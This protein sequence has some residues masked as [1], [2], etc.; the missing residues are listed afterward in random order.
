MN[1][2]TLRPGQALIQ[3][4]GLGLAQV[5]LNALGIDTFHV[6]GISIGYTLAAIPYF[7]WLYL[8]Q[9][10]LAER[11]DA[12]AYLGVHISKWMILYL[13]FILLP[14]NFFSINPP[15]GESPWAS[16]FQTLMPVA[17]I[18]IAIGMVFLA[19]VFVSFSRTIFFL[20]NGRMPLRNREHAMLL[21]S[22][23]LGPIGL[24][25]LQP[26]LNA[27]AGSEL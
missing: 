13:I 20:R 15:A 21:L 9:R 22:F 5:A 11:V 24:W 25:E 4:F 23:F 18:A 16:L 6:V 1:V 17:G 8:L 10:K 27:I 2:L 3:I 12:K 26:E 14:A 19:M 7:R